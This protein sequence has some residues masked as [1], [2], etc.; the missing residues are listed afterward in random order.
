MLAVT[1]VDIVKMDIEGSEFAVIEDML[2]C[3]VLP[4]Q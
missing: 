3:P 2:S 4:R 1:S